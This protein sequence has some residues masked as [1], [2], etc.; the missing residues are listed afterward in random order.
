MP[1]VAWSSLAPCAHPQRRWVCLG[2]THAPKCI[3]L[4]TRK[5]CKP[6]SHR[7]FARQLGPPDSA[8]RTAFQFTSATLRTNCTIAK[9]HMQTHPMVILRSASAAH[10]VDQSRV[11]SEVRWPYIWRHTPQW[12][13]AMGCS[14]PITASVDALRAQRKQRCGSNKISQCI[15]L[16]I[17]FCFFLVRTPIIVLPRF[18]QTHRTSGDERLPPFEGLSAGHHKIHDVDGNQDCSVGLA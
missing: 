16:Q 10:L 17:I 18:F 8:A 9:R 3:Q 4:R 13:N 1:L 14:R 11:K 6:A 12:N 7:P 15:L 5:P 2:T